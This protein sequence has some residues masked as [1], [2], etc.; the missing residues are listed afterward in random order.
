VLIQFDYEKETL[1]RVG[2]PDQ[3]RHS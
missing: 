3:H 2:L 1:H